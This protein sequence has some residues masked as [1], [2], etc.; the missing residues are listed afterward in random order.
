MTNPGCKFP[1]YPCEP[2]T[3]SGQVTHHKKIEG[4]HADS[5]CR[6]KSPEKLGG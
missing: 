4:F 6:Y 1:G 2:A 3:Y 5:R